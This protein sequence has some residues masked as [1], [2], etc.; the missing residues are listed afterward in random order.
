[1]SATE[2]A[3]RFEWPTRALFGALLAAC[4]LAALVAG[5]IVFAG[6][7]G[8]VAFAAAREWHRMVGTARYGLPVAATAGAVAAALISAVF[9]R[10]SLW[11]MWF[12]ALGSI[13]AAL[14][15]TMSGASAFW[16]GAG[17]LYIGVP[18]LALVALRNDSRAGVAAVLIVFVAVWA[19]DTGAFLGG[20][21]LKGPKLSP[22]LSPNKTWAGLRRRERFWHWQLRTLCGLARREVRGRPRC[23]GW[24]SLWQDIAA[25]SSN[26][27]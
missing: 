19:A 18:A 5:G 16:N 7:V 15:A 25:I 20:R 24:L 2:T 11:P 26:P 12:L 17:T 14:S 21:F 4:A 13:L 1:M 10:H 22:R 8:L 23:W 27:G 6:V 9:A 3:G